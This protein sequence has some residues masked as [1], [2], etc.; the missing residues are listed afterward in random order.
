M[1]NQVKANYVG[2]NAAGTGA[3]GNAQDGIYLN[4]ANSNTIGGTTAAERN[5]V[6]ANAGNGVRINGSFSNTVSGNYVGTDAAVHPG[7]CA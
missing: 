6:S 7:Q 1:E 2:L 3:L 5:V 4:G